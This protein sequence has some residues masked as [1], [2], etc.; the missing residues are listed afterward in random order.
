MTGRRHG[1]VAITLAGAMGLPALLSNLLM[2][3]DQP[4]RDF[5]AW[6]Y[7]KLAQ[8][9]IP[10]RPMNRYTACHQLRRAVELG[11]REPELVSQAARLLMV[12][13][14]Y[15]AALEALRKVPAT[16]LEAQLTYAHCLL[17]TGHADEGARL[18]FVATAAAQAERRQGLISLAAYATAMNNAGYALA[19]GG[20]HLEAAERM[21]SAAVALAPLQP[22]FCDSH[23]WVL[24][25]LQ[26]PTEAR[27]WLERAVRHQL[28]WPDPVLLYHLGAVYADAHCLEDA[29]RVLRWAVALDPARKDAEALLRH[30]H[31][32]LPPP[33]VAVRPGLS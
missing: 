27:F 9:E 15:A 19:E 17:M 26:R 22:A 30:L 28:P 8:R 10:R 12:C 21:T 1:Y 13:E 11:R 5:L 29:R 24:Y 16:G 23:G 2:L 18:V 32:V 20:V 31:R 25:K 7:L 14:D 33:A 3:L 4:R 6:Q